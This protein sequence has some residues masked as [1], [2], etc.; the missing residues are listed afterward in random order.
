MHAPDKADPDNPLDYL[1]LVR[2]IGL[3][4]YPQF[5]LEPNTY[6][7]PPVH[8]P[9]T[10]LRML[11]G[12]GVDRAIETYRGIPNDPDLAGLLKLFGSSAHVMPRWRRQGEHVLGL[13]E[14]GR[15]LCRVPLR[16][17]LKVLNAFDV[18]RRV[19]RTNCP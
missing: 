19:V 5:G 17:P 7:I 4:L 16:E 1:V 18:A 14:D 10:Y 12:P 11:F 3:P 8:V 15:E 13:A 6:Y 2:K 9:R